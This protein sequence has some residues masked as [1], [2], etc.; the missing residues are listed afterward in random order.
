MRATCPAHV[1]DIAGGVG[2]QASPIEDRDRRLSDRHELA[3]GVGHARRE[4]PRTGLFVWALS[5]VGS[6]HRVAHDPGHGLLLRVHFDRAY[7]FE[8]EAQIVEHDPLAC[9]LR[10]PERP[11]ALLKLTISSAALEQFPAEEIEK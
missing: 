11:P 5:Q 7:G 2:V 3:P 9:C 4:A 6:L 1:S 10:E 8:E